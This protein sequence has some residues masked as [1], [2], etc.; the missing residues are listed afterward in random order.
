MPRKTKITTPM[1][2]LPQIPA[3]LLDRLVT[4]PMTPGA[5]VALIYG[6]LKTS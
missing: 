6:P 4:G 3:E 2:T 5:N 1:T